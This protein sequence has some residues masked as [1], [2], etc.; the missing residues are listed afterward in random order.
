MHVLNQFLIT[1][2]SS[3][4]QLYSMAFLFLHD[5]HWIFL[6]ALIFLFLFLSLTYICN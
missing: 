1:G 4:M 6:F 5:L 3:A 2:I